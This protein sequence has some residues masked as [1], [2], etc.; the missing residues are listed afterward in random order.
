MKGSEPAGGLKR[1]KK[2]AYAGS[3]IRALTD[4]YQGS[5]FTKLK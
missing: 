5:A 2:P 3:A 4:A 1:R